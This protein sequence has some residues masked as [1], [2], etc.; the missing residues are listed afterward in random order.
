MRG[1]KKQIN[2]VKI[3]E[4]GRQKNVIYLVKSKNLQKQLFIPHIVA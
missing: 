2:N 1:K 4:K 3:Y